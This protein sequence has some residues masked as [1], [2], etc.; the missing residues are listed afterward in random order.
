MVSNMH[1]IMFVYLTYVE[2]IETIVRTDRNYL[3]DGCGN[4][5]LLIEGVLQGFH[6]AV[7]CQFW[8]CL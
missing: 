4:L 6:G 2:I 3:A 8:R 5:S 7:P 1:N